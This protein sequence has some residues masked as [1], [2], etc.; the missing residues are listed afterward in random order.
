M[1]G[2]A[3][4]IQADS[5]MME[6][7]LIGC[8]LN[9]SEPALRACNRVGI[10]PDSFMNP[11][12]SKIFETALDMQIEGRSVDLL[13]VHERLKAVGVLGNLGGYDELEKVASVPVTIGHVEYYA[14]QIKN[15][16]RQRKTEMIAKI[17]P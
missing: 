14:V 16:E 10:T 13:T 15:H 3:K 5:L 11:K 12:L 6:D 7:A 17:V 9:D 2:A 1:R 8:V 4:M